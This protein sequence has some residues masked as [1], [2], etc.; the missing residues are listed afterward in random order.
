VIRATV[1]TSI[2]APSVRRRGY[3]DHGLSPIIW[4]WLAGHYELVISEYILDEI[5]RT[6]ANTYFSRFL[7]PEDQ[8]AGVERFR[9]RAT[10]VPITAAV[11]GVATHP[12]DDLILATAVSGQVD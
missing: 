9:R 5:R 8:A 7:T 1:D 6:L 3:S 2:L 4:L 11:E 10:V 12:E